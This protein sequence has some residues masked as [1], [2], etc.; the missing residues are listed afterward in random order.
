MLE[1]GAFV[2]PEI[3]ALGLEHA[4]PAEPDPETLNG[5]VQRFRKRDVASDSPATLNNVAVA[6]KDAMQVREAFASVQTRGAVMFFS[7]LFF[8][9]FVPFANDIIYTYVGVFSNDGWFLKTQ[10]I[11][12]AVL[13]LF[14]FVP[15]AWAYF[16]I[17]FFGI[18][19]LPLIFDRKHR[20]IYRL[21]MPLDGSG[22][23]GFKR[24][25]SV[26]LDAVEYDWDLVTAEHRVEVAGTGSTVSRLHRL[27]LVARDRPREGEKYGRLLDEFSV[28]SSASLGEATVPMWWEHIRRFMEQ[29]G[30][31]VR[32]DEPLQVF[33]RPRNLWQSMGVT[34]PFGPKFLWWW[35]RQRFVTIFALVLL[36]ITLPFTWGW[37]LCN[38]ISHATMRKVIIPREVLERIGKAVRQG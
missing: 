23:R 21:L 19:D 37:A 8:L 31:A 24:F 12:V 17:D 34:G 27:M 18:E 14:V 15:R 22:D 25:A 35:Q 33:E 1:H 30:P 6:Y 36:P 20:K 7:G 29:G 10:L 16:R 5:V 28:G 4:P 9:L 13:V 38:W 11:F 32:D 3:K 2:A 26:R